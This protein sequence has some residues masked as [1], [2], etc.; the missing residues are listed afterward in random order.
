MNEQGLR[1]FADAVVPAQKSTLPPPPRLTLVDPCA[2]T[3]IVEA[4]PVVAPLSI[5]R[6]ALEHEII[7]AL[8]QGAMPGERTADAFRRK[9]HVIGNLFGSLSVDDSRCLHR[10]LTIPTQ[11]DPIATR[12]NRLT[13]ERKGRLIAFLA[14]ARRRA[15][16]VK[17]R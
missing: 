9:E 6:V 4:Q 16:L 12:M 13:P 5:V 2:E 3:M 17:G 14:D 15:A 1:L 8:D 11:N 10:R 7:A